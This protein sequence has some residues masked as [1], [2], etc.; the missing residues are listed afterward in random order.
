VHESGNGTNAKCRSYRAISECGGEAENICSHG[1]F[2]ILTHF[3]NRG[4]YAVSPWGFS[5]SKSFDIG[6]QIEASRIGFSY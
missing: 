2:R 1:V 5:G 6:W 4:E 3:G